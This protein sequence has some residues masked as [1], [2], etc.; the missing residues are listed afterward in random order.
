MGTQTPTPELRAVDRAATLAALQRSAGNA[1]VVRLLA[2]RAASAG[3][4]SPTRPAGPGHPVVQR[5][6]L[7][8]LVAAQQPGAPSAA[9]TS[10]AEG[11]GASGPAL[12][13]QP[14]PPDESIALS[15]TEPGSHPTSEMIGGG[16]D[17]GG[18]GGEGGGGGDQPTEL[19]PEQQAQAITADAAHSE[20]QISAVADSRRAEI[21]S[22]FGG[23]RRR[24]SGLLTSSAAGIQSFLTARQTE[25]RSVASAV[26]D[27]GQILLTGSVQTARGS[28]EQARATVDGVVS[29]ATTALTGQVESVA[30]RITG[31][32]DGLHLPDVP[33]VS[34]VR[35]GARALAGRAAGAVTSALN[36]ARGLIG[37][38]LQQGT[39][40]L[41]TALSGVEQA[42][43]SALGRVRSMVQQ[44]VQTVFAGLR[45]IGTAVI[46]GLRTA[47]QVTVI[48]AL[49]RAE[50]TLNG[51]LATAQSQ[52]LS[53]VRRNRDQ[54]LA[55]VRDGRAAADGGLDLVEESRQNNAK[56]VSTFRDRTGGIVTRVFETLSAG[57]AALAGH[58]QQFISRAIGL[59]EA[60]LTQ[61]VTRLR[62]AGEALA[63]FFSSLL[64]ELSS[65]VTA[66]VGFVR[67]AVS[68]PV[69]A[70]IGIAT[71]AVA[72]IGQFA[73]GLPARL[74]G[75]NFS[76]PGLSE[77]VDVRASGPIVK[78]PPGPIVK[79]ALQFLLLLFAVVGAIVLYVAPSLVAA[80]A[81]VLA[82]I[83]IT[84]SPVVLLAIVGVLALIAIA[85]L[86]LA[87]YAL[88]KLINP[89]PKPP[90][91][92]ITHATDFAA[93]DGSSNSRNE[94]GVAERVVFTGSA[95]GS[96][97]ASAGS[98]RRGTG[99]TFTWTAPSR[100]RTVTIRLTV[101]RGR[102]SERIGVV[103]PNSITA[104]KLSEFTIPPGKFGA[105]MMLDFEFGPLR[106][107]FG[108]AA[109]REVE[110]PASGIT[111]YYKRFGKS[112]LRH[113]PGPVR[114]FPIA[115]NNRF[116]G[117]VQDKAAWEDQPPPVSDGKFHWKIPNKF[118][119]AGESG[120]GKKYTTVKQEF[121]M[122]ASGRAHVDK[123]GAHVQHP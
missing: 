65:A 40:L 17:A 9:P 41:G 16:G 83:G 50:S 22:Q 33:G 54:H 110:G 75:G 36:G 28:I 119:V 6:P 48:R 57:A 15:E 123:A 46:N 27:Q 78:P 45:R 85:V 116:A 90:P 21:A 74:L 30:G 106:V 93:P 91:P 43:T 37:A 67:T 2:G 98:P 103:E 44:A 47:L 86:L 117:G 55:A 3:S 80:V 118:R 18:G 120:D 19:T 71:G 56:V 88:Y 89:G 59:V 39:R 102:A 35:S 32:V 73:S 61:V 112:F 24:A 49:D 10:S 87:L 105:G 111:G 11:S 12:D 92:V 7:A 25:V 58:I 121:T 95:P 109:T 53:S 26:F 69:D 64:S 76:L 68:T 104:H 81:A 60:P 79:P 84:V 29:S 72:R 100:R 122:E 70:V 113:N 62:Q 94:V 38:V 96:W 1:A 4:A 31:L 23:V 8:R 63:G 14:E 114:F 99:T 52:A 51:H 66:V 107:S 101:G 34:L 5:S 20:Q 97:T 13:Q 108:N 77:L 42:A 82:A 115:P